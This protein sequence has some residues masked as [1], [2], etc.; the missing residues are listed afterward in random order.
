[1]IMRW[2]CLMCSRI[3]F[4]LSLFSIHVQGQADHQSIYFVLKPPLF[5]QHFQELAYGEQTVCFTAQY[6][7][8]CTTFFIH[9]YY[10]NMSVN[11]LVFPLFPASCLPA[12]ATT[13]HMN[14]RL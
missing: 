2:V 6:H 5:L 8:V 3:L 11:L 9:Q 12:C 1:M 10:D 4:L 7:T 13:E 14:E